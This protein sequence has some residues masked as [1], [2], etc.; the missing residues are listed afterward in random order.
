MAGIDVM[1]NK[2]MRPMERSS[3]LSECNLPII[4]ELDVAVDIVR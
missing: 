4:H 1:M 3:T 2:L